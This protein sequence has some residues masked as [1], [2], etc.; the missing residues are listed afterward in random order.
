MRVLKSRVAFRGPV[1][2]VTSDRV[3]EPSGVEV[4][5]DVVRHQ[6]SVV[7]MAID[8]TRSGP[9]VLLVRQF[10]YAANDYL[11]E[12]PAGRID[13]G[14]SE[15]SAA[16]RELREETGYSAAEWKPALFFYS[17]PGFVQETMAVYLAR[18]L[19]RGQPQPEEDESIT[20]RFFP[21]S[22]V[23]R[24]IESGKVRDGKTIAGV[25]WLDRRLRQKPRQ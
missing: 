25:L 6:G 17:S 16:R 7:V 22:Q 3:V 24:M 23:A 11:W 2:S 12:L 5:R 18:D 8:E 15:L 21:V 1:F 19:R 14:E 4:R 20:L 10:R 13:H 9:R